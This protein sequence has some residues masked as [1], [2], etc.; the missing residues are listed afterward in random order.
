MNN[1]T[2][3]IDGLERRIDSKNDYSCSNLSKAVKSVLEEAT[4]S[5]SKWKN[6]A[7][8]LSQKIETINV[9]QASEEEKLIASMKEI[10]KT[11]KEIRSN[12]FSGRKSSTA[13][14]L[15]DL[16]DNKE[17]THSFNSLKTL[18][19]TINKDATTNNSKWQSKTREL[20]EKVNVIATSSRSEQEKLNEAFALINHSA[21]DIR[22]HFFG[23]S[24]STIATR[25]EKILEKK[26]SYFNCAAEKETLSRKKEELEAFKD[27][28]DVKKLTSEH[29]KLKQKLNE[30]AGELNPLKKQ[31]EKLTQT[32]LGV[33][34]Q[35][36][37]AKKK[38]DSFA[39][40]IACTDNVRKH[41]D[42]HSEC[43]FTQPVKEKQSK[44]KHII[45]D[46]TKVEFFHSVPSPRA[47]RTQPAA[48]IH[49]KVK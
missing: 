39:V 6:K 25:L 31:E 35:I 48:S 47:S 23:G 4:K 18:L 29:D 7:E 5:N 38:M 15:Q 20:I 45:K 17:N 32:L 44:M 49:K 8:A 11:V 2:K 22:D 1:L 28:P 46:S 14:A 9:S 3:E 40:E 12:F 34:Q 13:N 27:R 19:E 24:G 10:E 21:K 41:L 37:A 43:N 26:Q 36:I 33:N 42:T 16:M 30:V